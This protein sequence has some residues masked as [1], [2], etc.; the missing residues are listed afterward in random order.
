MS[1]AFGDSLP[2][3]GRKGEGQSFF[4]LWN[5]NALFLEI[6]IL[7]DKSSGVK[8]GSASPVGVAPADLGTLI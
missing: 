2:S 8:L 4:E 6:G 7:P 5:V 1:A 3:A